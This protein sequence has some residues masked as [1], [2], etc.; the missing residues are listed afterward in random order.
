MLLS[1]EAKEFIP[2][3]FSDGTGKSHPGTELLGAGS[4]GLVLEENCM[5]QQEPVNGLPSYMTTCY[6]FVAGGEPRYVYFFN[7]GN[8]IYIL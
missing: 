3:H 2:R 4:S 7:T 8:Q 1:P 6:P 5:T